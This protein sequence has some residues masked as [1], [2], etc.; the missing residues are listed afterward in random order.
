MIVY[1]EVHENKIRGF[2]ENTIF[3]GERGEGRHSGKNDLYPDTLRNQMMGCEGRQLS[4]W[5]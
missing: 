4:W 2:F 1:Q 5:G 3:V